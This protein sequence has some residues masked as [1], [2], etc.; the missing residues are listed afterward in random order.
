MRSLDRTLDCGRKVRGKLLKACGKPYLHVT[1][2]KNGKSVNYAV[3]RLVAEAFIPNPNMLPCINHKDENKQNNKMNNLEWC[4]Y[5]YNNDYSDIAKKAADKRRGK[6][7][8]Q[9]HKLAMSKTL[10]ASGAERA[11]KRLHTMHLLY[12]NGFKHSEKSKQQTSAK[13]SGIPKSVETRQ[14]MRKPKSP[15]HIEHMREA[16]R[17]SHIARKL[18][19]TYKDYVANIKGGG[20]NESV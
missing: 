8:S 5:G 16:Q 14:K 6:S 3:H 18:G 19:M 20:I 7:L 4:T 11:K 15:E 2:T 9:N 17:L 1:L 10:C 13:L 12:P